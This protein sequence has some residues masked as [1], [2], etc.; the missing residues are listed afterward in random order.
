MKSLPS[1]LVLAL[2]IAFCS[3]SWAIE[4]GEAPTFTANGSLKVCTAGEF[5]PMEFYAN[6][7]DTEM[8]GFEVDVINA[9]AK[10]WNVKPTLV[11][12]DFKSLLPSL[13]SQRC[14]LVIS[15]ISITKDR[16]KR[17][18]G[19]AYFKTSVVMVTSA[20][21]SDI[22]QPEDLSGKLV[23]LEAGTTYE[24]IAGQLNEKLIAQGKKPVAI[25]TYPSASAVIQQVL[26]GRAAATIT[27]DTTAA[28]RSSQLPGQLSIPYS[29]GDANY[30][31]IYMR[32]SAGD[33]S[34]VQQAISQMQQ[35][36]EF[37]ALLTKWNLPS[38]STDFKVADQ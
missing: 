17:Y 7:G 23:A 5:P 15:G 16:L 3:N 26:V 35:S 28:Y 30:F 27:Q 4:S 12:G 20:K 10:K 22:K 9:L 29:Y 21:N 6:P 31:G 13:D 1:P 37:G 25:Q 14:D 24:S 19:V 2:T 34:Q 18:D 32:Q 38:D 33:K 36:G 11:V 8:V